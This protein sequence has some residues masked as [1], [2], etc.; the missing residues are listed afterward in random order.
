MHKHKKR[1]KNIYIDTELLLPMYNAHSYF[2]LKIVGKKCA[3]YMAKYG[4]LF[5][6]VLDSTYE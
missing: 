3:L 1:M 5:F 2:S 4:S 6:Y